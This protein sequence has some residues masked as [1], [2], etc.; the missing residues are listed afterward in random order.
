MR[1]LWICSVVGCSTKSSDAD[2]GDTETRTD[3]AVQLTHETSSSP[4]AVMIVGD[5]NG[6]DSEHTELSRK[7]DGLWAVDLSLRPGSY[8]Y[9]FIEYTA[10]EHDGVELF[11]C[12]S[13]A[14]FAVCAEPTTGDNSWSQSCTA[15]AEDCDSLLIVPD[16]TRPVITVTAVSRADESVVI[17]GSIEEGSGGTVT[18]SAALNGEPI[19]VTHSGG[20]FHVEQPLQEGLR[21]HIT[22]SAVDALGAPSEPIAVPI[23]ADDWSWDQAVIYHALIDR[24]ANGDTSNDVPAGT[25]SPMTDWAGG[26]LAGLTASLPY[27]HD[28][29]INTVWLSNPQP[30]PPGAWPGTCE[31]TYS[32]YHGYWPTDWDGVDPHLGTLADLDTFIASAHDLKMRVIMDLVANHVHSDH[33]LAADTSRFHHEA[34]CSDVSADG[35]SNWDQIPESC[36]FT[37]YLPDLD[38]SQP[39]VMASSTEMAITWAREHRLDGLRI[40][41]AKHMSHAVIFN[42]RSG[43]SAALEHT[44]SGFDFNLIGETFDG[45]E[46]INRYMGPDLLHGQFDFPLYWTLRSA[47]AHDTASVEDAVRQAAAMATLYPGG[48]MSTF[49]GN[50]DVGRFVTDAAERTEDV[51]PAGELRTAVSPDSDNA[52]RRLALAWTVLFTQPG[53]PMVY[54]GDEMGLPG[55]GDPDNRQPLWWNDI[56]LQDSSVEAV[57]DALPDGPAHV[58]KTLARL[59]QARRDHPA[60]RR[61]TQ[62]EWW[63]GGPG[64]YATAHIHEED[65]A[66]VVINRTDTEQ[67]LDNGIGFA[68]LSGTE[69]TDL[70]SDAVAHNEDDR[71]IFSVPAFT[72]QVW[73]PAE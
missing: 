39:Q 9:S 18:L 52:Y 62:I 15:G 34:T 10:W 38:H 1:W 60:L 8:A 32:G 45:A 46:A 67:W 3:C 40:D 68:G 28:L 36:W 14:S 47:F 72:A 37:S 59:T 6:W 24:V 12:D 49:L 57:A 25:S 41:A 26:D 27:L 42:L 63:D 54:Y 17:E 22:I 65:Q 11:A 69:W 19:P 23:W 44:G 71:L 56:N 21:H 58:L 30:A 33:S 70:L 31:S 35:R 51:C 55:Y 4:D 50:L 48:R 29:G 73:V 2:S 66:I 53:M 16:C 64:L 7:S 61:G 20:V 13:S 43:L 5:F